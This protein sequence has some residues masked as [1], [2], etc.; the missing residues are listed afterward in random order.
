MLEELSAKFVT[1]RENKRYS[2]E[3]IPGELLEA[4]LDLS[5][6]IDSA[7][8]RKTLNIS[9]QQLERIKAIG[10]KRGETPPPEKFVEMK[11][12]GALAGGVNDQQ[13]K[14]DIHLP[15]GT[16]ISLSRLGGQSPMSIISNILGE[17]QLC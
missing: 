15:N 17:A 3:S 6:H 2:K 14:I 5:K 11:T 12:P 16:L 8:I 13:I 9:N 4:A 7:V 10:N 1:W